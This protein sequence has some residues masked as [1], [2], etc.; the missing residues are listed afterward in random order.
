[1]FFCFFVFP[2]IVSFFRFVFVCNYLFH[3]F[4]VFRS[5][6][7]VFVILIV[8]LVM[9]A[10]SPF[11][12][13]GRLFALGVRVFFCFALNYPSLPRPFTRLIT[14]YHEEIAF[15]RVSTLNFHHWG[16][17]NT[18]IALSTVFCLSEGK[19]PR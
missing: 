12:I 14:L 5:I 13:C 8:F 3:P 10:F 6:V 9:V 11:F 17:P 19:A 1:M 2:L 16:W 4:S 18:I 15:L 7:C